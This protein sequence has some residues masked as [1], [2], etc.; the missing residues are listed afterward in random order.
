MNG[1]HETWYSN[2]VQEEKITYKMGVAVGLHERWH[3]NGKPELQVV[4]DEDGSTEREK[5]FDREGNET[6]FPYDPDLPAE[7]P[8]LP[9]KDMPEPPEGFDPNAPPEE[10]PFSP[11]VVGTNPPFEPLN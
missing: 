10:L 11:D 7:D 2:G 3:D 9:P 4:Y 1:L 8:N 6:E 5:F